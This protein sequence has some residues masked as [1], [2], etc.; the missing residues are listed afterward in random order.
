MQEASK[1]NQPQTNADGDAK[2]SAVAAKDQ[3]RT[4]KGRWWLL[5]LLL[6]TIAPVVAS[7]FTYYVVRPQGSNFYG[8]LISPGVELPDLRAV[9]MQGHATDLRSLRGQ[10]LLITVDDASCDA[11][12]EKTLYLT[13][14]LHAGL[15]T[16]R[17]RLERVWL[18]TGNAPVSPTLLQALQGGTVL[19]ADA[20]RL[21]QWL[22]PAP[23][24][25]LTEHIYLVDPQGYWM[26]RFPATADV[27]NA[28]QIKKTL[29]RLLRA[30]K[31]WDRPGR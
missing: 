6:V 9:D 28:S 20:A 19:R 27:D 12:C 4:R 7:Y 26:M 29:N 14:Q 11:S 23:S 22:T 31:F 30:A 8:Q 24:Q 21:A 25:R 1:P 10:W 13:R 3:Q 15:G 16:E 18:A 17:E 5:M 2:G